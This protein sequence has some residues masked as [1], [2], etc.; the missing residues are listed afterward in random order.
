MY[1]ARL[2]LMD[3][4]GCALLALKYPSCTKLLGPV[5]HGTEVPNGVRVPGTTYRLDPIKAAFDIGTSIRWLDFN[6]TWLA[7]EWGHPSDNYGAILSIADYV[8]RKQKK[9]GKNPLLM[10]DVLIAAIKAYEIQGVIA[11]NNSFNSFGID[12]VLLVKIASTALSAYLLGCSRE[13]VSN[14]V[15]NAW[16]EATLRTYR[17]APNTGSRKSWAAGDACARGV[18]LGLMALTN[19]MGYPTAL[20][21]KDWGFQDVW[22][23]GEDIN[24]TRELG[25][26]VMDNILFNISFPAEFHGQTSVEAAIQLHAVVKDRLEEI[27]SIVITTQEPAI[28]II[29]KT[30]PLTNPADRDHCIQY[31]TAVSLIKGMLS[32]DDYEDSVAKNDPRIDNLRSKTK[33]VED[34]RFS[35]EYYEVDKR[36]IA[37]GVQVFFYDGSCTQNVVIEY[38]IGH[39]KR[40][41]QAIP[42]LFEKFGNN[43]STQI[44]S[45]RV[46]KLTNMFRSETGFD[47]INADEF[48]ELFY[49]S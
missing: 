21:T 23:N 31:M 3:S 2:T 42:L 27:S 12:H 37:N 11:L 33:V 28:R 25:S 18:Q 14:A 1:T 44:E 13:Q 46:L 26:Y 45:Q 39:K 40:R 7:A 22:G 49:A 30:G 20:T 19:E 4:I 35:R 38:P 36:S 48:M 32:S 15:S 47:D 5:V 6:D 34:E 8:S 24:I 9:Q 10:R 16:L 41:D 29:D 43:L 17:H